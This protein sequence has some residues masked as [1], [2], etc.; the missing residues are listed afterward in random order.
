MKLITAVV[1][2]ERLDEVVSA[3][4]GSGAHGLTVQE[5][6]GF[7]HQYGH[8]D[9]RHNEDL[10]ASLVPKIRLDMVVDSAAAERVVYALVHAART[11]TIGDGKIWVTPVD[12][13]IRVRTGQR[14]PDAV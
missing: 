11:G 1:K 4:I 12:S 6:R 7:G 8:P 10:G 5:V 13:I 14:G 2:P 9:P 3:V